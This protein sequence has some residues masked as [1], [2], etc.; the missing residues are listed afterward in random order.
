MKRSTVLT[1]TIGA[2]AVGTL[3]GTGLTGF[4]NAGPSDRTAVT[5]ERGPVSAEH[6]PGKQGKQGKQQRGPGKGWRAERGTMLHGEQV[7]KAP[8][9]AFVTYRNV[10][11][12]VTAVSDTSISLRAEDG[13]TATFTINADTAFGSKRQTGSAA[14]V[15]VGSDVGVMGRVNGSTAVAERVHLRQTSTQ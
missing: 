15:Q 12:T 1:S 6:G 9:G 8:D 11:G 5:A 2:L 10:H 7:V 14:D 13:F 4:A 3:L